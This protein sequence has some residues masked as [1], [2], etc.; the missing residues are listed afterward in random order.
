M[1]QDPFNVSVADQD[2]FLAGP[3]AFNGANA[4]QLIN[5]QYW[6][7]SFMIWQEAW[8]NFRRSG[9]PALA[10]NGYPGAD[11][12]VGTTGFIRRLPYP[13]RELS[14]N[15]ANVEAAIANMGGNDLATR[16]FWDTL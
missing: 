7:S 4:L 14:V 3:A 10:P 5:E 13:T 1:T 6:V 9:F 16:I 15:T 12:S 2:A 8:S 11:P